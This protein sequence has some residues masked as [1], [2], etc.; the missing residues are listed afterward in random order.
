MKTQSSTLPTVHSCRDP[1]RHPLPKATPKRKPAFQFLSLV[2]RVSL[3]SHTYP[4][5]LQHSSSHS[6]PLSI[7]NVHSDLFSVSTHELLKLICAKP[8]VEISWFSDPFFVP[9][10]LCGCH[11]CHWEAQLHSIFLSSLISL[12][13]SSCGQTDSS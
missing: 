9:T 10:A 13:S 5:L 11:T 3:I 4:S 12:Q 8:H 6:M 2:F 1:V 7:I